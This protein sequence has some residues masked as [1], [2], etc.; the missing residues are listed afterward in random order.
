MKKELRSAF[1]P[2]GYLLTAALGVGIKTVETAYEITEISKLL[3]FM[4]LMTYDYHGAWETAT[5]H[6]SPLYPRDVEKKEQKF[7]NVDMSL[8]FWLKNGAPRE[9]IVLGLASYGR[10]FTLSNSKYNGLGTRVNGAG[11]PMRV[12]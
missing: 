11:S 12:N 7:L 10:S 9:K 8:K 4:N 2:Y 3:D 1:K 6:P 5:G